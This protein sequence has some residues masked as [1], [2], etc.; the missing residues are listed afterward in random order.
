MHFIRA[1]LFF[2][3]L[4]QNSFAMS[5]I[6]KFSFNTKMTYIESATQQARG[7][8]IAPAG[9][10]DITISDKFKFF[11]KAS[12]LLE[13]GS[14]KSA[15]LDEFKPAQQVILNYAFFDFNP[16]LLTHFNFGAI[17]M[18]NWTADILISSTR[19]FG[20]SIN[21]AV[22]LWADAKLNLQ[23]LASI[24]SN[25]ELTNRLGGVSEG[26]PSYWQAGM[27]LDLPG[28]ILAIKAKGFVWAYDNINGNVAYQSGFMGNQTLGI[29]STNSTLAYKFNGYA[30]TIDFEGSFD[31]WS[32]G[33]G[34]D[35][36]FNDGAPN[37]RN[38]ATKF[39]MSLG[40]GDYQS[41]LAWF[42]IQSDAVIGYYNNALL[43]HTNRNG[44]SYQLEYQVDSSSKIIFDYVHSSVIKQ[45][46]V[47][48]DQDAV[49]FNWSYQLN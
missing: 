31:Q 12:I 9:S 29:G 48:S 8:G 1:F 42:E 21:Q 40:H 45:T 46:L 43:G 25:Q 23:A 44:L 16:W 6:H 24:P 38:Q 5:Y 10:L 26:T 27:Q 47:Q 19:F 30:G 17:P 18:K 3:F 39:R 37:E 32:W 33:L 34:V 13:T 35:Y 20:A 2:I 7:F 22:P 14:H 11:S 4:T 49:S 28:D 15:L 36:V 41:S